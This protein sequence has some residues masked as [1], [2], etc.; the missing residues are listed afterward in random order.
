MKT[1]LTALIARYD[2]PV[3]R[4]TSYPTVPFWEDNLSIERW[5]SEV[6]QAHQRGGKEGVSLYIH[7]PFCERLC[8]YCGCNKRITVNHAVEMPYLQTVL[9]EWAQYKALL[10][11][12]IILRELH[13]GGGTPTFFSA[14]NLKIL[15]NGILEGITLHPDYEFGVE[16]HPTVTT[17]AQL[18]TLFDMGF[19][20]LSVGVQD[21][22]EQVQY[23]INREQTFEQTYKTIATARV[24]GYTS[25]NIDLIYGL[26]RQT[27][28][29]VRQTIEKI[30]LLK[31]ERIAFYSYAHVPWKSKAQ[32][33][34]SEEDL[35]QG[36]EKR[37]LY[38]VGLEML[39]QAE[40]H[41]IGMDHFALPQDE[42]YLASTSG[43]L[44]RNF[45]GYTPRKTELLIGLG[46]SSI[47]DTGTSFAQNAKEV[48]NYQTQIATGNLAVERG[49]CLNE[50]DQI[51][52]K[53]ILDLLCQGHTS[54]EI[55][56]NHLSILP[57]GLER[58]KSL[59]QDN[60]V[61]LTPNSITITRLGKKFIRNIASQIDARLWRK[62]IEK[63]T[64]S[65]AV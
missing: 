19:Q 2:V 16:I 37:A 54:W 18:Q 3:P 5:K 58:L 10:G 13:L 59:A 61:E 63:P 6:Y 35:P 48:E 62:A 1:D 14:E 17:T 36:T 49:H 60:L 31:P 29:S 64:F 20:R 45:M 47:S 53:H 15:L 24:M 65:Q 4:Y 7:L 25:I 21:F 44:H 46:A 38:E 32:R 41:E 34:Y 9:A 52:R 40:Y 33:R 8:T 30:Q 57:E 51:L 23:I 39:Q 11:K 12:D 55:E 43:T 42:L 26:P 50:E 28:E 56:K 22:D 27:K